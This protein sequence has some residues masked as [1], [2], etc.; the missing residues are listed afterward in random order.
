MYHTA[1][2]TVAS[3][4]QHQS[5]AYRP[6][7]IL[8][9]S[10]DGLTSL[11]K[12]VST[13]DAITSHPMIKINLTCGRVFDASPSFLQHPSD[14][15][16]ACVPLQPDD[17]RHALPDLSQDDLSFLANP[18]SL[19]DLDKEWLH[20]HYALNHLSRDDM[21]KLARANVLPKKFLRYKNSAPFCASC[22]FGKGH[23]RQWR[24]KGKKHGTIRKL[25][26]NKP[27]NGVS[28]EQLVSA[29][30]GLVP[31]ISGRLTSSHIHCVTIFVDHFSSFVF[32]FLQRSTA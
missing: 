12:V 29:Q 17:Y 20:H 28:V 22:A 24:F 19:T 6:G 7:D 10:R 11:C 32:S 15:D 21:Y 5:L 31:Q 30:P 26:D 8:R 16:I 18:T 1:A 3:S 2:P 14:P 25:S 4:P 23:R 27:G 13:K 9:Y